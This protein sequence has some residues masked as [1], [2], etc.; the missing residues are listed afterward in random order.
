MTENT[1]ARLG[2]PVLAALL[3]LAAALA[4]IAWTAS[5]ASAAAKRGE[6]DISGQERDF[7]TSYVG[8]IKQQG[9][10]CGTAKDVTRSFH[11]CRHRRGGAN[12]HC[13]R[14]VQGWKC[15]EDRYNK[16]PYQ[17]NSK[18]TCKKGS[19]QIKSQYTQNT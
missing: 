5:D 4:A 3:A 15:D 10:D 19:A 12:G 18:V 11:K 16:S 9:T 7:N 2:V 6:C 14:E 8:Y 17:Y 13:T 1:A